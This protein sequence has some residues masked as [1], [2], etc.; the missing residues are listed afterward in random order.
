MGLG[1]TLSML[2]L[3]LKKKGRSQDVREWMAKPPAVEGGRGRKGKWRERGEREREREMEE[4]E[5][6]RE[7]GRRRRRMWEGIGDLHVGGGW[8]RKGRE[9]CGRG[10]G[11]GHGWK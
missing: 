5:E 8:E 3:V 11:W 4:G 6:G 1:K 10:G 2:S 9:E 7:R